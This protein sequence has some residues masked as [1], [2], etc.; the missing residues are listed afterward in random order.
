MASVYPTVGRQLLVDYIDG[1]TTSEAHWIAAGTGATSF[2]AT[3]T[4]ISTEV[5]EAR[6]S[7]TKSQNAADTNQW[8]GTQTY[9]GTKTVT[10]AGVFNSSSTGI[11]IVGVDGLSIAVNNGDSIQFTIRLQQT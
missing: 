8:L 4:Q 7:A 10:N 11:L 3:S 6:V 5:S 2:T 1:T 9:T